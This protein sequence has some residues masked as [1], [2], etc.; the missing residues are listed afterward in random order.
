MFGL[1]QKQVMVKLDHH[2]AMTGDDLRD[3]VDQ[4]LFLTYENLKHLLQV[5]TRLNIK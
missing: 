2:K 1:L 3:F 4:K 5:L